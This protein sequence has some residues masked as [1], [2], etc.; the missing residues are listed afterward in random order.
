M[1]SNY[2][3]SQTDDNIKIADIIMAM[4]ISMRFT[5]GKDIL[6][7]RIMSNDTF[8]QQTR[9]RQFEL[10]VK[11]KSIF[12]NAHYLAELSP[13][14]KVLCFENVFREAQNGRAEIKGERYDDIIELL[15]FICPNDDY[16]INRNIT[17]SN[18]ALLTHFS[19]L[20]QL[21]D[22]RHQLES[23]VVNKVRMENYKAKIENLLE[24]ITEALNA[25]FSQDLMNILYQKLAR[26]DL[27][28]VEAVSFS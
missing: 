26:Y 3:D 14:F 22:L 1:C 18:F 8:S 9:L 24:M 23:Y 28:Y 17:E 5:R 25:S 19:S 16:V 7:G 15:H 6:T 12:I 10:I 27:G 2:S 13:Y 21:R 20:L 4:E 11:K